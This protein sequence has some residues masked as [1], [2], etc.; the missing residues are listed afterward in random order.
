RYSDARGGLIDKRVICGGYADTFNL[1]A[2]KAG[3]ESIYVSGIIADSGS[4]HAWNHVKV[5]GVW[6]A[7]DTTWNDTDDITKYLLI[8]EADFTGVAERS[9]K[10]T[11]LGDPDHDLLRD[12]RHQ[13]AL[14]GVHAPRRESATSA[15][16][17]RLLH[18]E[19]PFVHARRAM[20][21]HRV[22]QTRDLQPGE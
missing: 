7:V 17:W 19:E 22:V 12:A 8:N 2:R 5:D 21:P 13:R 6:K 15:G 10:D 1:L 14:S 3:L 4:G 9:T 16:A 11:T 20:P 18:V